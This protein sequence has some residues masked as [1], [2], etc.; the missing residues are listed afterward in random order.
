MT[1]TINK[2]QKNPNV[3]NKQEHNFRSLK[4]NGRELHLKIYLR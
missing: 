4:G 3:P 2:E 1:T